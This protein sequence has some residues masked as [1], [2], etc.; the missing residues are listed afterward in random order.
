MD[1]QPKPE[2]LWLKMLH[3]Y[4]SDPRNVIG[5]P[6]DLVRR[7]TKFAWIVLTFY[8]LFW[9]AAPS[10][11]ASWRLWMRDAELAK[12]LAWGFTFASALCFAIVAYAAEGTRPL[13]VP[14]PF[15]E[16]EGSLRNVKIHT[17]HL[18]LPN[19]RVTIGSIFAVALFGMSLLG[20]WNYYLHENLATGGVSV[21]SAEGSTNRVA[22]AEA[23][24]AEHQ[25]QTQTALRQIDQAIADTP[26]GSPTGRSRLVAQRTALMTAAAAETTRLRDELRVAR[27]T[28]VEVASATTDPRP[29]DGIVAGATRIDRGVVAATLDLLRSAV[30][31]ALLVLGLGLGLAAAAPKKPKLEELEE[32][33][34]ERT[35]DAPQSPPENKPADEPPPPPPKRRFVLPTATEEDL[36]LAVAIGPHRPAPQPAPQDGPTEPIDP[37]AEP[38]PP[39]QPKPPVEPANDDLLGD[40]DLT[41]DPLIKERMANV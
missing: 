26:P 38:T 7:I 31:E 32:E 5:Q 2:N 20:M 17:T 24:L 3:D 35:T 21:A 19:V 41:A 11:V 8:V 30:V 16:F 39:E 25:E 4:W 22:E 33:Q 9:V 13:R 29:V 28:T 18:H 27:E 34:F 14:V 36:R 1:P 12:D 6:G 40:D 37:P 23:A 15:F 10:Q